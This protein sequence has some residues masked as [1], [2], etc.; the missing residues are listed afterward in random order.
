MSQRDDL[1]ATS[2]KRRMPGST[3]DQGDIRFTTADEPSDVIVVLNYLRYDTVLSARSGYIWTW[4][5]EPIVRTPFAK[6]FDRV[7]TH[8]ESDDRRTQLSPPILD[9]WVD[10]THDEL[11]EMEPPEK[12]HKLSTIASTKQTIEG[13]R[14][15]NTFIAAASR[16]IDCLHLY[17]RGRKRTIVDKWDGL[18]DYEFSIAIENTSKAD[19][20]TEKISD[21]FLSYTVPFY[22]GAPNI[23]DYF[24]DNS[25]IWLP[26]EEPKRAIRIIEDA[27]REDEWA[28]RL[29][30]LREARE[31]VLQRY[32][33]HAQL[34]RK[35]RSER[36]KILASPRA[37]V[38]V[39]G[40]R[41]RK[42][43][44]VRGA[45]LLGNLHVLRQRRQA[46]LATGRSSLSPGS[47]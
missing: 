47:V 10:K 24:P 8:V 36:D 41:T 16:S 11:E 14:R 7:Y 39:H 44:W 13:H 23:R 31:L 40:R 30:A 28:S 3:L 22:F 43:G 29:P 38:R 18:R 33:A 1:D 15:R 2:V 12:Q 21:C 17:G 5:N 19:Y 45:G 20:W 35:I 4:H 25:F 9:W 37:E 26:I 6:G 46:R 32:S 27:L 42:G 34:A